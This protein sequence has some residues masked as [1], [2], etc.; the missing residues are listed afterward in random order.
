MQALFVGKIA[1]RVKRAFLLFHPVPPL[2]APQR[3]PGKTMHAF[4]EK[5]GVG[6]DSV[7]SN[8]FWKE[9]FTRVIMLLKAEEN[10]AGR[11]RDT[12]GCHGIRSRVQIKKLYHCY[13]MERSVEEAR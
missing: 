12:F 6:V 4:P 11:I 3:V 5:G 13:K 7:S 2:S 10:F 8:A 9:S 1:H